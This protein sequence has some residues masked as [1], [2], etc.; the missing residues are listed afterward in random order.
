MILR[1]TLVVL[2]WFGVY[3]IAQNLSNQ[4]SNKMNWSKQQF[5]VYLFVVAFITGYIL[6]KYYSVPI[7]LVEGFGSRSKMFD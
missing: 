5:M 1:E 6:H 4:L 2:Y 3:T 7:G